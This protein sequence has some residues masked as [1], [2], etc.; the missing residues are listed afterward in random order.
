[1][2]K[3][4][5]DPSQFVDDSLKGIIAANPSQLKFAGDD[6]RAV[7]RADAPVQDKVAIVTGGGY[8]HLPTFLGFVGAGLCDGVAVGNVFTSP[9]AETIVA[10]SQAV[11][12]GKGVLF[13]FGN[14][15]GDT[16]NF[17]MAGEVLAMDD[18]TT[19]IVKA[20][21]DIASAPRQEWQE[22]RGVAGL[23]FA[24]KLAGAKADSGASLDE[25]VEL[26]E[27]VCAKTATMGI[28]LS[29]CQL[30]GA[31]KPIFEIGDNEMELG[32]G[33]H[34]E[35][36]VER[37]ELKTSAEIAKL[38]IDGLVADL[39]LE[40]GTEVAIL[41]NGLGATSRE[42]L[43]ILFNDARALLEEKGVRIARTYVKEFA[44]SME[45][46]GAS[47]S[48]LVLNEDWKTLLDAPAETPFVKL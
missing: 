45:M 6:I 42:E 23:F 26:T 29:S 46:K 31:S 20:S 43:Y 13:L 18:I 38:I 36:G 16:M 21:D 37:S 14:Y 1:M 28:A 44:T 33:I 22:R 39:S 41:V 32:M 48:L 5:N 40:K 27:A 4:M 34:G 10:A 35:P 11:H 17:E 3:I 30:P 25:V 24:Y 2:K 8:G 9:S 12:G 15:S 7:V 47:I 19:R